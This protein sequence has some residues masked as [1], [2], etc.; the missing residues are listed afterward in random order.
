MFNSEAVQTVSHDCIYCV[1]AASLG[2]SGKTLGNS[3]TQKGNLNT[4]HHYNALSN[5][6]VLKFTKTEVVQAETT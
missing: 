5:S 4:S 6:R 1:L 3:K 2:L